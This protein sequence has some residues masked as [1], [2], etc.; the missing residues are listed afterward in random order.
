MS[1]PLDDARSAYGNLTS[2]QQSALDRAAGALGVGVLQLMEIAGW[3]V[4]RWLFAAAGGRPTGVLVVA[5]HGNNGGDGLVA[6]RHLTTWGC[7]VRVALVADPDRLGEPAA[8]HLAA[9][10]A[11]GV[12]VEV[13]PDGRVPGPLVDGAAM[14][15]DALLGSGIRGDPRPAQAEAISRLPPER[16][17]AVDVPSGLDASS[18]DAGTPT[19]RALRTCTL[20]AVKAG[21]WTAVGRGHAGQITV[22]DIGMPAAAWAAA[23]LLAPSL[24]RGGELLTIPTDTPVAGVTSPG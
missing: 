7:P 14:V 3:Q 24:V 8:A 20:T 1:G 22:A 2:E 15:V 9:L 5:G 12:P 23:G 4:A 13:V 18:G 16:T 11:L 17:H 19:V 21:L 6:A 10:R